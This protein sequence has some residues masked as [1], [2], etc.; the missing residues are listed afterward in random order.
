MGPA[1]GY[2]HVRRRAALAG[3]VPRHP[4]VDVDVIEL[5]LRMPPE[6]AFHPRHTRP[7]VREAMKGLIPD[8]VRLRPTK[9]SFDALFHES[10]AGVD[11]PAVRELVDR[12]DAEVGAFVDLAVL[13]R[14][15]FGAP[16]PSSDPRAL[17]D[18][19]LRVWRT[20]TAEVWLQDQAAPGFAA[21]LRANAQLATPDL[22]LARNSA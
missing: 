17:Q 14:E 9:S 13:R 2:D 19:A 15:L 1:L 16:P 10:I 7:M 11:L 12:P 6:T 4:L 3:I 20:V 21:D 22:V 8:S 18:W 5:M